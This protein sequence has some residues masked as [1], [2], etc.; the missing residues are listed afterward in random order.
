MLDPV[1]IAEQTF[2]IHL[3]HVR[4]DEWRSLNG[5][6][7]CGDGGKGSA[8]DRFRVFTGAKPRY[9]CR[10]CGKTG[11]LDE[12]RQLTE[13][14]KLEARIRALEQKAVEHERRM[15]RL[16]QLQ[17]TSPHLAYH[18]RLLRDEAAMEYW[19][20][21]GMT[22]ETI[23]HY[24]LGYCDRCPTDNE[25]RASYTIPVESNGR[26]WNIRHR[27]I[28]GDPGD[29]Y[30]PHMAGLPT[31]LFNADYLREAE[32]ARILIVEGEKKSIIAAQSGFANVGIMGKSGFLREWVPKFERF[33][34]VYVALDPDATQNA[35]QLAR[36][37]GER[38]RVVLLPAKF[39]DLIV[40]YGA[41]AE[42]I[43]GFLASAVPFSKVEV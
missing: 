33:A 42:D 28:G 13:S 11:F 27:L 10:K 4:G 30:R 41:G 15:T 14:E 5:C 7:F 8:S 29:K 20:S 23:N 16:E 6:P 35:A 34:R 1:I 22:S 36:L 17:A 21:E 25:G 3:K 26:L 40:K 43:E 39:D 32:P 18:R 37:F 12:A 19:F 31:V 9:W 24:H 2:G 38:G